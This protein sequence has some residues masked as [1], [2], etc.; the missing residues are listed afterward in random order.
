MRRLLVLSCL[1]LLVSCGGRV[2]QSRR[3]VDRELPSERAPVHEV[4]AWSI[5]SQGT[6]DGA[7]GVVRLMELDNLY[8]IELNRFMITP[9]PGLHVY[10]SKDGT[11]NNAVDL[12]QLQA[13]EGYQSYG[14]PGWVKAREY[15]S[16]LVYSKE[17]GRLA[18]ARLS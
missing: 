17:S 3:F 13:P 2:E 18:I 7:E 6:M 11:L 8:V 14:V 5:V 1:V 4:P 9:S 16:V 12:G 15:Q 10:L